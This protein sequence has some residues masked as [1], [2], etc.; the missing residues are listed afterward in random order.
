MLI[1]AFITVMVI[2]HKYIL[3][4]YYHHYHYHYHFIIIIIVTVNVTVTVIVIISIYEGLHCTLPQN[5]IKGISL[6]TA[7]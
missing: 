2:L 4:C 7:T 3:Y 1:A 6:M 5:F